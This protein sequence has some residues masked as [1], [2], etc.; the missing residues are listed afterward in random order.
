MH[1]FLLCVSLLLLL[2]LVASGAGAPIQ[3][4]DILVADQGLGSP[5]LLD[6]AV[7]RVD[8]VTGAQT[9]IT[10]GVNLLNPGG[11]AV[12]PE[13]TI[14]VM[15]AGEFRSDDAKLVRVV[16]E[17]G[18]QSVLSSG[19]NFNDAVGI[20]VTPSGRIFVAEP[21]VGGAADGKII[22]VDPTTG[23]QIVIATG[24]DFWGVSIASDGE[25][26]ITDNGA[27]SFAGV[28]YRLDP[29]G[30]L[31]Q[32]VSSGGDFGFLRGI[33]E[34]SN[35][36]VLVADRDAFGGAGA[37]FR[38]NPSDGIQFTLST[39][40]PL[41]DPVDVAV[42]QSGDI[43]VV[44]FRSFQSDQGVYRIDAGTGVATALST[45]GNFVSIKGI[46]VVPEAPAGWLGFAAT[47]LIAGLRGRRALPIFRG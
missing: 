46:T 44:D 19:D 16:P 26:W 23:A 13:G 6:G 5:G 37:V 27:D 17:S 43:V 7:I 42:E 3:L 4:G 8:P 28:L 21:G 1:R 40:S 33:A 35:G 14:L 20:A 39:G 22:E 31:P 11:V 32:A 34:D 30:G 10:S 2:P 18:A 9:V 12:E 29:D 45:G 36:Q 24:I 47:A 25:L 41:N 15:D 38:V